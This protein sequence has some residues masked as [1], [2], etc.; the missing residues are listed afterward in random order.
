FTTHMLGWKGFFYVMATPENQSI[1]GSVEN[2][3]AM[4]KSGLV[5]TLY[6]LL[7]LGVGVISFKR[8]DILS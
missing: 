6:T 1:P 5:L 8:K 4:V 2:P 7:F 3:W